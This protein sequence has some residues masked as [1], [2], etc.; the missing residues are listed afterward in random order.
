[1]SS[2]EHLPNVQDSGPFPTSQN[3]NKKEHLG[4]WRDVLVLFHTALPENLNSVPSVKNKSRLGRKR[5]LL[6]LG[7]LD[8]QTLLLIKGVGKWNRDQK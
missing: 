2:I 8:K 6:Q 5:P 7:C 3:L 1:M 4:A